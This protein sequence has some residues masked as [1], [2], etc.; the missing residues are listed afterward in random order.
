MVAGERRGQGLPQRSAAW[1][2]R[3]ESSSEERLHILGALLVGRNQEARKKLSRETEETEGRGARESESARRAANPSKKLE[4]TAAFRDEALYPI[5]RLTT[6]RFEPYQLLLFPPFRVSDRRRRSEIKVSTLRFSLVHSGL[7]VMAARG[8][9]PL[10][11]VILTEFVQTDPQNFKATVQHLTGKD[12]PVSGSSTK[13][14]A[15]SGGTVMEFHE[16]GLMRDANEDCING[17]GPVKMEN[18]TVDDFRWLLEMP[19]LDEQAPW[20]QMRS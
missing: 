13:R 15:A 4:R 11:R 10:V 16:G 17:V 3:T 14:P 20:P 5:S 9:K 12:A 1:H 7:T 6:T 2:G 18:W 8:K 19:S